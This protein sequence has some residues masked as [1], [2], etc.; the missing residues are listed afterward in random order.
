VGCP[1]PRAAQLTRALKDAKLPW[2]VDPDWDD[3]ERSGYI[4]WTL[5]GEDA[6]FEL[7]RQVASDGSVMLSVR[8]GGDPREHAAEAQGFEETSDSSLG[9]ANLRP[10]SFSS[11]LTPKKPFIRPPS[12]PLPPPPITRF[13]GMSFM[14]LAAIFSMTRI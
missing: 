13:S 10:V 12:P 3:A 6:G 11:R 1:F 8:W 4:A 2:S 5:N 9:A 14:L 7:R